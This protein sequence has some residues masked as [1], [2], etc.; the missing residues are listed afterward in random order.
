[1]H[2]FELELWGEIVEGALPTLK[3]SL[4]LNVKLASPDL[5]IPRFPAGRPAAFLLP[6]SGEWTFPMT[7]RM[8]K[9][10]PRSSG[11]TSVTA[12]TSALSFSGAWWNPQSYESCFI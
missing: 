1:K 9:R 12:T 7:T 6:A 5:F 8:P 10:W 2:Q 4:Q 11:A 3:E